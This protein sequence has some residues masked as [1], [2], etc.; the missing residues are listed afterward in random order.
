MPKFRRFTLIE[1]LVVV[2]I[3]AILASL[4][5]PALSKARGKAQQVSCASNI[6]QMGLALALYSTDWDDLMAPS[7]QGSKT[8]WSY[9]TWAATLSPYLGGEETIGDGT[10]WQDVRYPGK[11]LECPAD[12]EKAT[13]LGYRP[14]GQR[15][16]LSY[17]YNATF[18]NSFWLDDGNRWGGH[19]QFGPEVFGAK[20]IE[21]TAQRSEWVEGYNY[22]TYTSLP[23]IILAETPSGK[24]TNNY[25]Y[26]TGVSAMSS[27]VS[28]DLEF[29]HNYRTN[30]LAVDG[31]VFT[32]GL[33]D[34]TWQPNRYGDFKIHIF[35]PDRIN[36]LA[37]Q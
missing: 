6:K 14:D 11:V 27:T 17:G 9:Q 37:G 7:R 24:L 29:N 30:A 12:E 16:K 35:D 5:L 13:M 34:V 21:E 19:W 26:S 28:N 32:V 25:R 23:L 8:N 3:I 20:T 18:Y 1:L 2:A 36:Y 15:P 31:H 22:P 33:L 10:T 4:L